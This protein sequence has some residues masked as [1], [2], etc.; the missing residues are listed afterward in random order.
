[1]TL[2]IKDVKMKFCSG[3][4]MINCVDQNV[5][6]CLCEEISLIELSYSN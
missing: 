6:A 3:E 1:M 2:L 5:V 4:M